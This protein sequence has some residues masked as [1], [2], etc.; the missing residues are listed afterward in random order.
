MYYNNN[1]IVFLDGEFQKATDARIDLYSQSLHYGYSVFEGIRSYRTDNEETRVFKA[2]EHYER[3]RN[4]AAAMNIPF[5]KIGIVS[6]GSVSVDSEDWGNICN[7][8]EKYDNAISKL[9]AGHD[10]EAALGML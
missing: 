7:W 3:L 4:S 9:L 5:E 6:G 8:K 1:T 10:G 2:K